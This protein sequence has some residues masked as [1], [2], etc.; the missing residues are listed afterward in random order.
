VSDLRLHIG[1]EQAKA[2]WK[3]LNVQAGPNV[4]FVGTCT[5]LGA[6]DD[7]TVAEIYA[8]HVLEHLSYTEELP[9]ALKEFHRVL[10]PGGRL[11]VSVPDFEKLCRIFLLPEMTPQLRF[12]VMRM[13]FGGQMDAHDFHKVGLSGELLAAMLANAGFGDLNQ[14]DSFGEFSDSS[15]LK[16]GPNRV[17]LNV[18]A[19]RR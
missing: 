7:G 14:V 19:W 5:D 11:R 17:S 13:I 8:S 1:G 2:G 9:Q 6:F 10:K 3:I 12:H 16:F 4:D 15:D 18:V